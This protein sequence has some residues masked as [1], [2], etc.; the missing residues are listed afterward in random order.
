[1]DGTDS[2]KE[3]VYRISTR[4]PTEHS[5]ASMQIALMAARAGEFVPMS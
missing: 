3:F 5:A 1:M 4:I 2:G